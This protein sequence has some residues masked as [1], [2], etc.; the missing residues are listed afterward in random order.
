MVPTES[1][2][3]DAWLLPRPLFTDTAFLEAAGENAVTASVNTL[4]VKIR[5]LSFM[6]V[7]FLI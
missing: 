6:I 1:V 4:A 3:G 5:E 7:K 2:V